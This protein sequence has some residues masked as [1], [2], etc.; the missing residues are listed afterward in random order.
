MRVEDPLPVVISLRE[1]IVPDPEE[2]I[3]PVD[4][5]EPDIPP[6]P[7]EPVVSVVPVLPDM[8]LVQLLKYCWQSPD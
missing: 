1:P 3:V 6:D 2:P 8:P 7:V 4:L 5:V